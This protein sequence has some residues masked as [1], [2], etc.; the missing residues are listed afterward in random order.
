MPQK[1]KSLF[2]LI[3]A[4][5]I[6]LSPLS[7][8]CAAV[9]GDE[10]TAEYTIA[11]T[12]NAGTFDNGV[13]WTLDDSGLLY[14]TGTGDVP[15]YAFARQHFDDAEKITTVVIEESITKVGRYSFRGLH[16]L[17]EVF[18]PRSVKELSGEAFSN[19]GVTRVELSEGLEVI[20]NDAFLSCRHLESI[21]IPK[22]VKEIGEDAFS[23]CSSLRSFEIPDGFETVAAGL[24]SN[25]PALKYVKI[26]AAVKR[27]ERAAFERCTGLE[28]IDIPDSVT[29]IGYDTF[30]ECTSLKEIGIPE[31]VAVIDVDSFCG[32]TALETVDLPSTVTAISTQAFYGCSSLENITLPDRVRTLNPNAFGNCEKLKTFTFPDSVQSIGYEC[33]S[34]CPSLETVTIP[35]NVKVPGRDIFAKT[36]NI[37]DIYLYADPSKL[38]WE[39]EEETGYKV[40]NETI[41]HVLP[42]Y[43]DI[44]NEKYPEKNV[45]FE[46]AVLN[47]SYSWD[48]IDGKL[49]CIAEIVGED[50]YVLSR[51]TAPAD[52]TIIKPT[53]EEDG[54]AAYTAVFDDEY[55]ETQTMDSPI[56]KTGHKWSTPEYEWSDSECTAL[57]ICENDASHIE[58]ET[59]TPVR[60]VIKAPTCDEDGESFYEAN[61]ENPVFSYQTR[62][63]AD[64]AFGHKW[65]VTDWVWEGLSKVTAWLRC[66][67]DDAHT[68]TC[69]LPVSVTTI[70]PTC[71]EKGY[72]IYKA[73]YDDYSIERTE[74]LD[75]IGHSWSAPVWEWKDDTANLIFCCEHNALH[76]RQ[77]PP[78]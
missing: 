53:C 75:E 22:S 21:D 24:L 26:P 43:L 32:C 64:P 9:Q 14:V 17:K 69:D 10:D 49:S 3:L 72:S 11:K 38:K 65:S 27:I 2:A 18:L 63:T 45:T 19:C 74:T 13:S 48:I 62:D 67:N 12:V 15:S 68:S 58:T 52:E 73:V 28:S 70:A 41:C 5:S 29:Y 33:L 20:G 35:Q 50:G 51:E 16:Y 39:D 55:F 37:S 42:Q 59:V 76:T 40:N 44:Y 78:R 31:G 47:T 56:P 71:E 30:S 46:A 6:F 57:Q 7:I 36:Y 54:L 23:G 66:E 61:F 1:Y 34:R 60:T 25:C 77:Y 8:P 4:I